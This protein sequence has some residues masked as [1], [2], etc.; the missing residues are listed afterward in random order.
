MEGLGMKRS[1]IVAVLLLMVLLFS[2]LAVRLY[3]LSCGDAQISAAADTH[4]SYTVKVANVRGT[5]YD[6]DGKPLVNRTSRYVALVAPQAGS[7]QQQLSALLPHVKNGISVLSLL[8]SGKPFCVEVD[9]ANI[10][11]EGITVEKV[12]V[13]YGAGALAPHLVGYINSDGEGV[14]GLEKAFNSI[15]EGQSGSMTANFAVDAMGRLLRGLSPAVR[16]GEASKSG[17][18][19]T[20]DSEIQQVTQQAAA[21]YLKTGA[22][23]VMDVKTGDILAL[24]SMP[25]FSQDNLEESLT[26]SGSPLL[27][28]A[29]SAYDLGSVFKICVTATALENNIPT[30]YTVDC[31]GKI[32]VSGRIF[33]CHKLAGHGEQDME[34][35]LS[36]SCNPYFISLGQLVGGEKILS[37]AKRLGFGQ[38]T[39][40]A[41]GFKPSAGV[42]PT[43]AELQLPASLANFSIGQGTFMATPI[44][45]AR[46]ICAV[47]NGGCLPTPRLVKAL[48]GEN[49]KITKSYPSAA[50]QR[51]FSQQISDALVRFL[52]NTVDVGTGTPAK[53]AVGGAGGK[54]A[55]AQTGW[56]Q[57]GKTIDEAWFAGFYPAA[58]PRYAIVVVAEAG[59]AGGTSAGPVFRDIADRLASLCGLSASGA[60]AAAASSAAAG[61][62]G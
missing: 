24:A 52:I 62:A 59:D 7:T 33:H 56:K 53:P 44:Q 2:G 12:P 45:V 22:A 48:V 51:V 41:P 19:L 61:K 9:T 34:Q 47:A 42:L 49:G 26:T 25:T 50:P 10:S 3:Y 18:E 8:Q 1:R 20:L 17:V 37:M 16:N 60:S 30:S 40:L 11:A 36:N 28:R 15:L 4:G 38:T 14:A 55:T 46:M 35:A 43:E 39:E 27:N 32:D 5:I 31:T 57:D 23:V 13:R 54:T 21:K 6:A 29:F 58:S